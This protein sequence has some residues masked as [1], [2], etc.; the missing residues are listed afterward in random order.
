MEI[1]HWLRYA[2]QDVAWRIPYIKYL[3]KVFTAPNQY[4]LLRERAAAAL[5]T[6]GDP[7]VAA[8]FEQAAKSIVAQIRQLACLGIGV[9]GQPEGASV[10]IPL[11]KD[12]GNDVQLAAAL[13]LRRD[14]H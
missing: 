8:I 1:A 9:L 5:I 14:S 13:G 2:P 7:T 11:L 12:G 4:P 3:G 6:T 10:I